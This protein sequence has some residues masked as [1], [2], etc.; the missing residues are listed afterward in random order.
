MEG[1]LVEG[2]KGQWL[3][4]QRGGIVDVVRYL[5]D[6]LTGDTLPIKRQRLTAFF[7]TNRV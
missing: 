3:N 6:V 5:Q 4:H 1:G 2:V 7:M